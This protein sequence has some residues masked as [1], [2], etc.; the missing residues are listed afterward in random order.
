MH[1]LSV[2]TYT[3][4]EIM[5][6]INLSIIW[7]FSYEESIAPIYFW[8]KTWN[9]QWK[10]NSNSYSMVCPTLFYFIFACTSNLDGIEKQI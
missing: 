3:G 2:Q 4:E 9:T 8:R 7:D 5:Q 6:E 10:G 1:G